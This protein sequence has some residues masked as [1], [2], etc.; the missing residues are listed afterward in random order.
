[1]KLTV[2]VA[3][4]ATLLLGMSSLSAR[5]EDTERDSRS[6]EKVYRESC[7]ACHGLGGNGRGQAA[8]TLKT[9]PRDFTTG[10]YKFRSTPSGSLPLDQDILRTIAKGVRATSMLPQL[11][12]SEEERRAVVQ[13]IK[14][15]SLRFKERRPE[16][17]ISIPPRP[18]RDKALIALGKTLY[19]EAGCPSCHGLE[20]KGDG[21]SAEGL[22][23][24]WGFPIQPADLT[25]K[26]FKSGPD[27]EDLYR[28][29]ST[30]LDGTPM[31]SYADSLTPKELWR[32]VFYILSIATQE[33]PRGMMGLVGEETQG[34]RVD[35]RA[36]MAG[37]MG[38]R[39]MMGRGGGMMDRNMRD[40]M[41]DM[42]GR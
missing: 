26:P 14:N 42:M 33:R 41:K 3:T 34:M 30:G 6:G 13:Y 21:P 24:Y 32:L 28:T 9:K 17:P 12:L 36:A 1:M 27:P 15:F 10:I 2:F 23:D 38:G 16:Q 11:H 5:G 35:M 19:K 18:P 25:L 8:S 20:G 22:K 37:M 39:G 40:M 4:I 7:S 29:L 31:P